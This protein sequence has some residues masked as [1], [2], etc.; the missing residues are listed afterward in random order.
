MI[1][2]RGY[3][4]HKWDGKT[5]YST[6]ALLNEDVPREINRFGILLITAA[7]LLLFG[8]GHIALNLRISLASEQ[9]AGLR[10]TEAALRM[11]NERMALTVHKALKLETLEKV[12]TSKFKMVKPEA[13]QMLVLP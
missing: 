12:A 6:T 13:S 3:L 7:M 5:V 2:A 1:T 8:A 11:E 10:E 9:L 4:D